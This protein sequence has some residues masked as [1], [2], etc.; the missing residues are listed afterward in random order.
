MLRHCGGWVQPIIKPINACRT[1]PLSASNLKHMLTP[2]AMRS[3][4]AD[5]G[6]KL[7]VPLST[8]TP[9]VHH[10]FRDDPAPP[11][12]AAEVRA[13]AATERRHSTTSLRITAQQVYSLFDAQLPYIA[14]TNANKRRLYQQQKQQKLEE[15]Q[16]T[17]AAAAGEGAEQSSTGSPSAGKNKRRRAETWSGS[18]QSG[19]TV[20]AAAAASA[21][22][23]DDPIASLTAVP[24]PS[25]V[26]S[27]PSSHVARAALAYL[28]QWQEERGSW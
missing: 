12:K 8:L 2:Q 10:A 20:V 14:M 4:R 13:A 23:A 17:A 1:T 27:L 6:G 3:G 16:S 25:S 26:P 7:R 22:R 28:R 21:D 9:A 19:N 18:E 11:A 24:V 5:C 15:Q